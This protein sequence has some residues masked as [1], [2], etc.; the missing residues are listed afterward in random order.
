[1]KTHPLSGTI[2]LDHL[3]SGTPNGPAHDE[4]RTRYARPGDLDG[5]PLGRT[6]DNSG[7]SGGAPF[8]FQ[9]EFEGN[10]GVSGA[11]S[12]PRSG[13]LENYANNSSRRR[14]PDGEDCALS[15]N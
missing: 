3:P 5:A 14:L 8:V 12:A 7:S 6:L 11:L 15:A 13:A 9:P 10:D 1:M 2:E 4:L